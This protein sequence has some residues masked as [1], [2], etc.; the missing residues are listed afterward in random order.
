MDDELYPIAETIAETISIDNQMKPAKRKVSHV[1]RKPQRDKQRK[2]NWDQDS[3]TQEQI[4]ERRDQ[5]GEIN[6]SADWE[7]LASTTIRIEPNTE[8]PRAAAPPPLT[9][10]D[11]D[12]ANAAIGHIERLE[13]FKARVASTEDAQMLSL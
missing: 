9:K 6:F 4:S 12:H 8:T 2:Q 11:A 10:R 1:Q 3:A 7:Q 13:D 5:D